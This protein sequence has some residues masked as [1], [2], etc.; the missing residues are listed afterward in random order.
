MAADVRT[1]NSLD[2][3]RLPYAASKS[4]LQFSIARSLSQILLHGA[5]E[6]PT[7]N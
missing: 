3:Q 4:S 5:R 6:I 7:H 2:P 1:L